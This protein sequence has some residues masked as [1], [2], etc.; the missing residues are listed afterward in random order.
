MIKV[1]ILID[2]ICYL[3]QLYSLQY[4]NFKLSKIYQCQMIIHHAIIE[5][6]KYKEK[7]NILMFWTKHLSSNQKN[8][9]HCTKPFSSCCPL[10]SSFTKCFLGFRDELGHGAIREKLSKLTKRKNNRGLN[11]MA[12]ARGI[13]IDPNRKQEINY[14]WGLGIASKNQAEAL[15]LFQGLKLLNSSYIK[16]ITVIG[17]SSIVI[18]LRNYTV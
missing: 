2:K 3:E 17:Y 18:R 11:G 7:A 1:L 12:G 15:A 5:T 14:E 10:L 9:C 13:V 16:N 8:N 6:P 4:I